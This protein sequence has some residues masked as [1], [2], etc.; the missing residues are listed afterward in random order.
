MEHWFD[1]LAKGLAS[2][3]VS[4]REVL[5][6]S[7]Q[8]AVAAAVG[9]VLPTRAMARAGSGKPV[10]PVAPFSTEQR[11]PCSISRDGRTTTLK[12]GVQSVLNGKQLT[13]GCEITFDPGATRGD[14][15]SIKITSTTTVRLGDDPL[16]TINRDS[17]GGSTQFK[18]SYGQAF[19][20]VHEAVFTSDGK[21]IEGTVDNRAI[22]SHPVGADFSTIKYADG[23][24]AP[25]VK[26]DAAVGNALSALMKQA[27]DTASTCKNAGGSRSSNDADNWLQ[28]LARRRRASSFGSRPVAEIASLSPAALALAPSALGALEPLAV[29]DGF[30]EGFGMGQIG[31]SGCTDC[32]NDCAGTYAE[33]EAAAGGGCVAAFICPPCGAACEGLALV[34]CSV[35]GGDCLSACD[36]AGN[37]CCP[38]ACSSNGSCCGKGQQCTPNGNCCP[39]GVQICNNQC[40]SPGGICCGSAC[41]SPGQI[42]KDGVCC[43][44]D[45][46]VCH[47]VCCAEGSVCSTEGICC[48]P[49]KNGR[50]PISCSGTCCSGEQKCGKP[51]PGSGGICCD[52]EHICG[53]FC[54]QAGC[55]NGNECQ[56]TCLVGVFCGS[57]CCS[58][59]CDN[60]AKST[61]KPA[62]ECAKGQYVCAPDAV[63]V[64]NVC[65][66]NGTGCLNGKCCPTGKVPCNNV[67]TGAYGCWPQSQCAVIAPPK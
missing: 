2:G 28:S 24:P 19:Q 29:P 51:F 65:C 60:A 12:Y 14:A 55:V 13:H 54:C 59:G 66:A 57:S 58:W 32:Q 9:S 50:T 44:A 37:A 16:L 25:G 30:G 48:K 40:C 36:D 35:A 27:K 15:K 49:I 6:L 63:G 17:Q 22:S 39:G 45:R 42:C 3:G 38:V 11:G 23:N 53:D 67:T 4:R 43:A 10:S 34:A 52:P 8:G 64:G 26:L 61:C 33:C 7:I 5:K 62:Q 20:G 1:G 47:G 21:T 56:P 31:G 41:C 18:Y 46:N